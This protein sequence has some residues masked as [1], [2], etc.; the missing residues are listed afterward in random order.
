MNRNNNMMTAEERDVFGLPEAQEP[1]RRSK[2]FLCMELETH[3]ASVDF[4][5]INRIE[6]VEGIRITAEMVEHGKFKGLWLHTFFLD[7]MGAELLKND[8]IDG[9]YTIDGLDVAEFFKTALVEIDF[10]GHIIVTEDLTEYS[11]MC[12]GSVSENSID[13]YLNGTGYTELVSSR[14]EVHL[15]K[16]IQSVILGY[17]ERIIPQELYID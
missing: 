14:L 11:T 1:K 15:Y 2:Y 6:N 16:D 13:H 17:M 12:N 8:Y 7:T 9:E 10:K 5:A 4:F 3:N